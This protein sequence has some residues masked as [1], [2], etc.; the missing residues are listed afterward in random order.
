MIEQD[1]KYLTHEEF[2]RRVEAQYSRDLYITKCGPGN[3][4]LTI[5]DIDGV[6]DPLVIQANKF[7][8]GGEQRDFCWKG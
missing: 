7:M 5:Y 4:C 8:K 1:I 2:F 6:L 3:L